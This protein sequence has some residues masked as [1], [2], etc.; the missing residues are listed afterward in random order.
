LANN[1]QKSWNGR[2][3]SYCYGGNGERCGETN[4]DAWT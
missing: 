2:C 3:R 1:M 4:F